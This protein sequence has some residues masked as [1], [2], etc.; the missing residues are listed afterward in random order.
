MRQH[1]DQE[2]PIEELAESTRA[3]YKRIAKAL[4]TKASRHHRLKRV[5]PTQ[6]VAAFLSMR[7]DYAMRTFR[8]YKSALTFWLVENGQE[9]IAA[10]AKLKAS[11]SAGLAKR[12]TRTSGR[13]QKSITPEDH[14]ALLEYLDAKRAR[15]G[16]ATDLHDLLS[17]AYL[18]GLRPEEWRQAELTDRQITAPSQATHTLVAR[19]AKATHGRANGPSRDLHLQLDLDEAAAMAATIARFQ[20]L[21]DRDFKHYYKKLRDLMYRSVRLL[22][23]RRSKYPSIYT[24][25]HQFKANA[26]AGGA[27]PAEVA[28]S[29]GHAS[30]HTAPRNYGRNGRRGRGNENDKNLLRAWPDAISLAAVR[31]KSLTQRLGLDTGPADVPG[32]TET[33]EKT[34]PTNK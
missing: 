19:N 11:T 18:A 20:R 32:P 34:D 13:K 31:N 15:W 4:I 24:A 14:T 25:R 10:F 1:T 30:D 28:A 22:W 27:S 9:H 17:S 7:N 5:N 16:L 6:V 21:T 8:L 26:V 2:T 23:P 33:P 29:L 12:S 3:Q